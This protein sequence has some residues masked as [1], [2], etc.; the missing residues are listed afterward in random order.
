MELNHKIA[1]GSVQFGLDYGISNNT[2]RTPGHE[3][4]K[5]LDYASASGIDTI[6]TAEAYGDAEEVLGSL[7]ENKFRIV[8]K[9][10]HLEN[11]ETL[12]ERL[13]KCL[14]KLHSKSIYGYLAHRPYELLK[15]PRLWKDLNELK[16]EGKI[17]K[18][19]AS[20]NSPI[21]FTQLLENN[22]KPDLIQVPYNILDN[23]FVEVMKTIKDYGGEVHTRSTFLQGLFFVNTESLSSHFKS[24]KPLI[25]NLQTQ[26]KSNLAGSLLKFTLC[27]QFIDRVVLGVENLK[28]LKENLSQIQNSETPQLVIQD[29]DEKIIS[30]SLWPK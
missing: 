17:L 6:D 5:I 13:D 23:R 27:N 1:L 24:V 9:F 28:Q 10:I 25:K 7:L 16:A 4:K 15:T 26:H 20:L 11:D 14:I 3:V 21:E 8:S 29:V 22:I 30:P 18:I 2:G 19:G 12:K